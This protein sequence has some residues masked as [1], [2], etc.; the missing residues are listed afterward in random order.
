MAKQFWPLFPLCATVL[1][2]FHDSAS[3]SPQTQWVAMVSQSVVWQQWRYILPKNQA[4]AILTSYSPCFTISA[5]SQDPAS[6]SSR[7]YGSN[8]I[9]FFLKNISKQFWLT[10][11]CCATISTLSHDAVLSFPKNQWVAMVAQAVA[12]PKMTLYFVQKR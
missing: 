6:N 1:T 11:L 8:D 4:R 10:I 12:L 7:R 9:I 5:L 3:I 2:F